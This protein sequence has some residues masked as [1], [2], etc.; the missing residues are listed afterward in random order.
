[1]W[2]FCLTDGG[3]CDVKFSPFGGSPVSICVCSQSSSMVVHHQ[4][5]GLAFCLANDLFRI[6]MRSMS[7]R[8]HL[9]G[10]GYSC[11][12]RQPTRLIPWLLFQSNDT[13]QCYCPSWAR[14]SGFLPT[15]SP[16]ILLPPHHHLPYAAL[17]SLLPS[18][19]PLVERHELPL[20]QPTPRCM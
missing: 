10:V 4:S 17:F 20:P 6:A 19:R 16:A 1:M 15:T 11:C 5:N 18:R 2:C 13:Y 12:L 8:P 3:K 14:T 7:L 9:I